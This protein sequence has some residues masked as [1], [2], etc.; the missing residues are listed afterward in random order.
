M[1]KLIPLL[2]VAALAL[3]ACG[4]SGDDGKTIKIGLFHRV[5]DRKLRTTRR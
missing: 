3:T 5:A 2:T 4:G 1:R